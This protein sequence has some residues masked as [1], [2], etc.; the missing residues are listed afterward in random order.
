MIFKVMCHEIQNKINEEL[1]IMAAFGWGGINEGRNVS[2]QKLNYYDYQISIN[3]FLKKI[4]NYLNFIIIWLQICL[5]Y[6]K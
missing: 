5:F 3:K 6:L 4:Y 2:F 1:I